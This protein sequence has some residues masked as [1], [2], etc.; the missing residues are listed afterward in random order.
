MT[1]AQM[2]KKKSEESKACLLLCIATNWRCSKWSCLTSWA[3][4]A[5]YHT[6]HTNHTN[7]ANGRQCRVSFGGKAPGLTQPSDCISYRQYLL[8]QILIP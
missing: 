2:G 5:C 8:S 6:N 1:V 3:W 7:H 4:Y